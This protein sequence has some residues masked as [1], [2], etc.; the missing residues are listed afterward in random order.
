[1]ANDQFTIS[2]AGRVKRRRVETIAEDLRLFDLLSSKEAGE[3]EA[4]LVRIAATEAAGSNV[5]RRIEAT[6]ANIAEKL[7]TRVLA[8]DFEMELDTLDSEVSQTIPTAEHVLRI[9]ETVA[10]RLIRELEKLAF[11]HA[12]KAPKVLNDELERIGAHGIELASQLSGITSAEQALNAGRGDAWLE[13]GNLIES[14]G[15]VYRLA[16]ELREAGVVPKPDRISA[17]GPWWKFKTPVA[18][19]KRRPADED[20]RLKFLDE[21]AAGLYLPASEEVAESVRRVHEAAED[22]FWQ[23]LED[24]K[25]HGATR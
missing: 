12:G 19:G 6:R 11:Q 20:P 1:M 2:N 18:L 21:C 3:V 8:G 7:L 16:S 13:V 23:K 24:E 5:S 10:E 4:V 14:R 25:P 22:E 17:W 15:R 9:T